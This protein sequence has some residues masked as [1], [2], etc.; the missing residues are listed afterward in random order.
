MPSAA[1]PSAWS[2]AGPHPKGVWA[3][4]SPLP[5]LVAS[6]AKAATA[7][8]PTATGGPVT[9]ALWPVAPVPTTAA[10]SAPDVDAP[11]IR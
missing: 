6:V 11:G 3:L 1:S 7:T 10:D 5:R 4:V 9:V 2:P 8:W